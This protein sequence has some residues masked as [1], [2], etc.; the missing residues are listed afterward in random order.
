MDTDLLIG[1]RVKH[2]SFGI[3]EIT[4]AKGEKIR[5]AFESGD[6]KAFQ[7]PQAFT[8]YLEIDDTSLM[9][10]ILKEEQERKVKEDIRRK[11]ETEEQE[12]QARQ[13]TEKKHAHI[14][15]ERFG[16]RTYGLTSGTREEPRMYGDGIIGPETSFA[17]HAD[18][19]NSCFGFHYKIYQKAYKVLGNGYSVWFPNIARKVGNQYLSSDEYSGWLNI[20]SDSGDTITQYDNIELS[21]K[22]RADDTNRRII[23]ARFDNDKRYRF[24]GVYAYPERIENA[25]RHTRI[26][27]MFDTKKMKIIE[28]AA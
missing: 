14:S 1:R 9:Q 25:R 20:L 28:S 10:E 4:S 22:G 12:L 26:A 24:I 21:R 16:Q 5:V 23:F 13:M 27:T 3:G 19:L 7:F 17:T 11:K 6:T 8:A 18:A 15:V 2:K